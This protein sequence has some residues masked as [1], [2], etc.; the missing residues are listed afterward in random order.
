MASR[1]ARRDFLESPAGM[2]LYLLWLVWTAA[3][4]GTPT[5]V[6]IGSGVLAA[7]CLVL[8]VRTL[9]CR[10]HGR[11]ARRTGAESSDT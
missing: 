7:I 4:S 5:W 9:I 10:H 6:R 8:L 2:G 3:S 11:Q 1:N